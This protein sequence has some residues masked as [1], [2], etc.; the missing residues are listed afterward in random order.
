M[1]KIN[2]NLL[3]LCSS[4]S[5]LLVLTVRQRLSRPRSVN[6]LATRPRTCKEINSYGHP[7]RQELPIHRPL[8]ARLTSN[9]LK[10]PKS[11][12]LQVRRLTIS[13]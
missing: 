7:L 11:S 13:I 9:R 12:R 2:H 1:L 10:R 4:E 3:L 8:S 6:H 5:R